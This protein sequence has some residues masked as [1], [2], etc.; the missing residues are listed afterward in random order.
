MWWVLVGSSTVL[1]ERGWRLT[2]AQHP[3]LSNLT[4]LYSYLALGLFWIALV[5]VFKTW[6]YSR[7]CFPK[8]SMAKTAV[9]LGPFT[10]H[11]PLT[12]SR[13]GL[14][15]RT[16]AAIKPRRATRSW[17]QAVPVV[18]WWHPTQPSQRYRGFEL[19]WHIW[20]TN[21]YGG[22]GERG[23]QQRPRGADAP[24]PPRRELELPLS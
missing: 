20:N 5:G 4:L 15:L 19:K 10:P 17:L 24:C 12:L 18:L 2:G 21:G 16:S 22:P 6:A 14:Y 7:D 1:K 23:Q 8:G 13:W 11:S 3:W 9:G